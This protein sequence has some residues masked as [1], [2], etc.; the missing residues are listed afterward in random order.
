MLLV[1]SRLRGAL[2]SAMNSETPQETND[3]NEESDFG[4]R[5]ISPPE[6]EA[7]EILEPTRSSQGKA[8]FEGQRKIPFTVEP[9]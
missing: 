7:S 6:Y 1:R 9:E 2:Q 8:T 3:P 5:T 4:F